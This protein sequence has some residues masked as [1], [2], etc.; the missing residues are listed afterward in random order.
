MSKELRKFIFTLALLTSIVLLYNIIIC[1]INYSFSNNISIP[2]KNIVIL[3]DSHLRNSLNPKKM[4]SA[5]N[6]CENGE[7]YY[8]T[9]LKMRFFLDN[10]LD[11]DTAII[12][13]GQQNIAA[14][15]DF[16]LNDE[17]WCNSFF[18]RYYLLFNDI[19]KV[20]DIPIKYFSLTTHFFKYMC[21]IPKSNHYKNF[22]GK[23][24]SIE[25]ER[26]INGKIKRSSVN[27]YKKIADKH[28]DKY[29]GISEICISYLDSI[30]ILCNKHRITPI[31]IGSPVYS[32]YY[33]LIPKEIK[34]RYN[35]EKQKYRSQ[36]IIVID[37]TKSDYN[38]D[39]FFNADHLNKLGA[40][41]FTTEI[42]D[43]ILVKSNKKL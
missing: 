43:S 14:F 10:G 17:Y 39:N 23:F 1:I 21:L 22:I 7:P 26:K 15:N 42:I 33:N 4:H 25:N 27:N 9:Y 6:L 24:V 3:G 28:Y 32:K 2:K 12:G 11:P 38:I 8:L 40:N 19:L 37:L 41:N 16:K 36:K 34:K 30:I 29:P 35:I 5:Q 31:L 13:F 20:P 18:D